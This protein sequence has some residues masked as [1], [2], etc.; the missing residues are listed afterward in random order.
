MFF[1]WASMARV[2]SF[3]QGRFEEVV[4][5]ESVRVFGGSDHL[6]NPQRPVL[7]GFAECQAKLLSEKVQTL[8]TGPDRQYPQ[9][10]L[11]QQVFRFFGE[12]TETIESIRLS[13]R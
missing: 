1:A 2:R 4:R 6:H 5:R 11:E 10:D 7:V 9:H 3:G 12:G 8:D 13:W